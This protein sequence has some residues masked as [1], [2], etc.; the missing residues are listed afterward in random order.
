MGETVNFEYEGAEPSGGVFSIIIGAIHDLDTNEMD[1]QKILVALH[2]SLCGVLGMSQKDI[3][4]W[5]ELTYYFSR[6]CMNAREM[7]APPHRLL[8]SKNNS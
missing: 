4:R 8:V 6:R 7:D 2:E 5:N 1:S 3:F